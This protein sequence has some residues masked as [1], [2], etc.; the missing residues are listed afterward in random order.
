[1][2]CNLARVREESPT[3]V[4]IEEMDHLLEWGDDPRRFVIEEAARRGVGIS[5]LE[6]SLYR[7]GR[8]DLAW[9]ARK[10]NLIS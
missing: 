4:L 10:A 6:R 5:S 1:M 2:D 7:V 9:Y 8:N 3:L